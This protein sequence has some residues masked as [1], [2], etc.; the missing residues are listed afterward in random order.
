L[1]FVS[2]SVIKK[3][4]VSLIVLFI[5]Q[6]MMVDEA[7]IDPVGGGS[8]THGSTSGHRSGTKRNASQM[9]P[10]SPRL[11]IKRKPGPI[12]R[13][14]IVR[15]PTYP[16]PPSSPLHSPSSSP[17]PNTLWPS[18]PLDVTYS[19]VTDTEMSVES[20]RGEA[21]TTAPDLEGSE[22]P[23]LTMVNGDLGE[24]NA[25]SL[26]CHSFYVCILCLFSTVL[27]RLVCLVHLYSQILSPAGPSHLA[28][29][30]NECS[31]HIDTV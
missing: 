5:L 15:R 16:S 28:N 27:L 11:P 1:Y 12:P 10:S 4:V 13:H 6:R 9:D 17:S 29:F 21:L 22:P 19:P 24:L 26:Q 20:G 31:N 23:K 8:G 2:H 3:N 14:V 25:G 7:D 30:F 18:P